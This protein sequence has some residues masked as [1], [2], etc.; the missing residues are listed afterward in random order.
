MRG[1]VFLQAIGNLRG[2]PRNGWLFALNACGASATIDVL[3]WAVGDK[4]GRLWIAPFAATALILIAASY[5]CA[6][7]IIGREASPRGYLRFTLASIALALPLGLALLI[8]I[9]TKPHLSL[10]GRVGLLLSGLVVTFALESLLAAWP[11]A[12]SMSSNLVSP[13]R[14][15]RAT[16]GY[17]W[18]LILLAVTATGFSR[19]N[20]V[21]EMSMAVT[22]SQALLVAVGRAAIEM[23]TIA[24]GAAVAAAAW[25][26]A[27]DDDPSLDPSSSAAD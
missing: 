14:V 5:V 25:Q 2:I 20:I 27:V 17:R 19:A 26:F 7:G 21:P 12:Q 16:R 1:N 13:V 3:S 24:F 18:L 10:G 6:V 15:W 8:L 22:V 11:V 23:L 4:F 9:S